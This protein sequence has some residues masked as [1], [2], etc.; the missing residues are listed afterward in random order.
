MNSEEEG[1]PLI[2][3]ELVGIAW[4]RGVWRLTS[5]RRYQ[6]PDLAVARWKLVFTYFPS[7]EQATPEQDFDH[8][9]TLH[10]EAWWWEDAAV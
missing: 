4:P 7:P 6:W 2:S 9:P 10:I 8:W 3:E 5:A 1:A